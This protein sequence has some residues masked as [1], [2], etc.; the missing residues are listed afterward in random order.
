M[1]DDESGRPSLLSGLWACLVGGAFIAGLLAYLDPAREWEECPTYG[2]SGD[3]S[4]FENADWDLYFP[5]VLTGWVYL[6]VIEQ[7]LPITYRHRRRAI[8]VARGILAVAGTLLVSC[9]LLASVLLV[10]RH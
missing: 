7:A 4:A 9:Y 1:D 6:V 3:S 10:C 8:A 2:G 5:L